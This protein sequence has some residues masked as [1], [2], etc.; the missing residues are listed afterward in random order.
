[1]FSIMFSHTHSP[2]LASSLPF[3]QEL[4][5][6]VGKFGLSGN[7]AMKPMRFLSGGQKSRAGKKGGREGGWETG[8]DDN[9]RMHRSLTPHTRSYTA[10]ALLAHRKPHIVILDEPTNH[11]DMDTIQALIEAV[12]LSLNC[13]TFFL[14]LL[15]SLFTNAFT[16]HVF[17]FPFQPI[18][19]LT[20][21]HIFP[22]LIL[23][24]FKL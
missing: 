23:P 1:M 14:I 2:S 18:N 9:T 10:F 15:P 6:L 8:Q 16:M 5:S 20:F 7:D 17:L 13:F 12:S 21:K 19:L 11:L 3:S 24:F 4:R 22:L